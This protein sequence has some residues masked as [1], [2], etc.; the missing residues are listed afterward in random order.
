[1]IRSPAVARACHSESATRVLAARVPL[2]S[3]S[4]PASFQNF[5]GSARDSYFSRMRY[6]RSSLHLWAVG[7][8]EK[9]KTGLNF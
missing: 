3:D 7:R 1:M 6:L 2:I 8:G 4:F 9:T 5:Y